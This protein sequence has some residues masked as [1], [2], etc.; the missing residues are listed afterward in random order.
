MHK[1][2]GN[3]LPSIPDTRFHPR[4]MPAGS[5]EE[6]LLSMT[7]STSVYVRLIQKMQKSTLK[8]QRSQEKILLQ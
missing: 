8:I 5:E 3:N 7:V 1:S 4:V 2:F 6:F